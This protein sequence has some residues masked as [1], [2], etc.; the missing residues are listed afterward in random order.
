MADGDR[1]GIERVV[2]E[3]ALRQ[4]KLRAQHASDLSLV[5][6]AVSGDDDLHL[7][8][9]VLED[10][11]AALLEHRQDRAAGLSDADG[12]RR[13]PAH[14][15][16]LQRRFARRV[17]SQEGTQVACDLEQ[18]GAVG[19]GVGDDGAGRK[20]HA[21]SGKQGKP[22]SGQPGID[23]EDQRR[24][25]GLRSSLSETHLGILLATIGRRLEGYVWGTAGMN[26]A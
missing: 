8:G 16:F 14:E 18:P 6:L 22:G 20:D 1:D 13:V 15:Q 26:P 17:L 23:A 3:L 21:R 5:R 11:Y 19:S 10:G 24:K 25:G 2:V 7:R 9:L 4:R 12:A